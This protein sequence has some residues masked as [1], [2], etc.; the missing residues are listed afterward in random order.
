MVV[1]AVAAGVRLSDA[2]GRGWQ[3]DAM[4]GRCRGGLA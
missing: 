4:A 2:C 3:D 1:T